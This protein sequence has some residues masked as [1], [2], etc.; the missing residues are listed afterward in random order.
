M[1]P[2]DRRE[3]TLAI[4][5]VDTAWDVAIW[6]GCAQGLGAVSPTGRA[7]PQRGPSGGSNLDGRSEPIAHLQDRA[8]TAGTRLRGLG[9]V[10][11]KALRRGTFR[12]LSR[13]RRAAGSLKILSD[14][15]HIQAAHRRG[16]LEREGSCLLRFAADEHE[17]YGARCDVVSSALAE[18]RRLPLR[19][20]LRTPPLGLEFAPH[21]PPIPEAR[22][23]SWC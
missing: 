13:R 7:C 6:D 15:V 2:I 8:G 9:A 19:S 17:T 14:F 10:A 5:E 18:K 11:R 4:N 12:R 21:N 20:S 1:N 22:N 16:S 3:L 23:T